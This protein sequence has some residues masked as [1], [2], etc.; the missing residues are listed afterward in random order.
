MSIISFGYA[1]VINVLAYF[2]MG[3]DKKLAQRGGR[4][5]RIPERTLLTIALFGGATGTWLAMRHFRHKTKHV[6]F[7]CS[8]P[9]LAVVQVVLA[10]LAIQYD[11]R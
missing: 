8:L 10:V 4:L 5:R 2:A 11:A 3:W 1:V 7:A 6:L 9:V